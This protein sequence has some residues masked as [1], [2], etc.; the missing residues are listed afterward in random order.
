M[1]QTVT[2]DSLYYNKYQYKA[3]LESIQGAWFIHN[4]ASVEQFEEKLTDDFWISIYNSNVKKPDF[5]FLKNLILYKQKHSNNVTIRI[6]GSHVSIFSN[7]LEVLREIEIY[8]K[9]K[10][11]YKIN[12]FPKI[13]FFQNPPKFM[14]RTYFDINKNVDNSAL[15]SYLKKE[16]SLNKLKYH[17][18]FDKIEQ[19]RWFDPKCYVDYNDENVLTFVSLVLN[20]KLKQTYKL[21]WIGNK[22]KY[23]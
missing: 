18:Y 11:Y 22:D 15:I 8:Y 9:V 1:I 21:E 3:Q 2:K 16:K 17:N 6:E 20:G 23:I 14:F 7:D 5:N 13:K 10:S 12:L 19:R 4:V